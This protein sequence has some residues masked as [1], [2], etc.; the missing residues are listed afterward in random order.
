M[1]YEFKRLGEVEALNE[2][3]ENAN[4]LVEVGGAIKRVPGSSLGGGSSEVVI[5]PETEL[6]MVDDLGGQGGQYVLM[7]P[8][9][10]VPTVGGSCRLMWGGV[11]Y[12]VKAV[13]VSSDVAGADGVALGNTS[14]L[15]LDNVENPGADMPILVVL[16]PDGVIED[17]DDP[18]VY[19]MA[20]SRGVTPDPPVLSIVQVGAASGGGESM[21]FTTM[22]TRASDGTVTLDKSYDELVAAYK[23]GKLVKAMI[24][25][26]GMTL[27]LPAVALNQTSPNDN[28]YFSLY[29]KISSSASM[30]ASLSYNNRNGTITY[31]GGY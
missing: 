31:D 24:D 4:V 17:P 29:M 21:V 11:E 25:D 8:F 28:L 9:E 10:N 14:C 27:T 18:V 26:A 1:S 7:S 23:A 30:W 22:A 13:K 6:Q 19:C 2:V 3:P 16:F 15:G 12:I 5:L 20:V